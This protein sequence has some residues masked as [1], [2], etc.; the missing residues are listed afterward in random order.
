M[1]KKE[2]M[3]EIDP[4]MTQI[5]ADKNLINIMIFN[6]IPYKAIENRSQIFLRLICVNLRH[7][8]ISFFHLGFVFPYFRD[9]LHHP[10]G[11]R[12]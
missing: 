9:H 3:E 1:R 12:P 2:E 10:E 4:Q 11:R 7:L 8:R 6:D 5:N